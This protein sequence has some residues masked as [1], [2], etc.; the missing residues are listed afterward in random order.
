MEIDPADQFQSPPGRKAERN[1]ITVP[2]SMWALALFQSPPGR[3][4]ER[5]AEQATVASAVDVSI[6]ARP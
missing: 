6:P 3:K 1:L 2:R 4:A 5:N